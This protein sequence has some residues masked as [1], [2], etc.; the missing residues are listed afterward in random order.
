M[1]RYLQNEKTLKRKGQWEKFQTAVGEY[2]DLH[3]AEPV[4]SADLCKTEADCFYLPMHGVVKEASTTTKLRIVFD[5]S[6][7]TSTGYSINNSL[8]PGP[9]LYPLLVDILLNFR[10]YPI[11][12]SSDSSERSTYT[13]QRKTFTVTYGETASQASFMTGE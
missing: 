10:R 2:A 4:P 8:L 6:A 13:H 5:A 9:T 12:M 3:H 7:K 11:A 1:R